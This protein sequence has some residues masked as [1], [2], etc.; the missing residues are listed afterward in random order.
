MCICTI[1]RIFPC[2][3]SCIIL[4]IPKYNSKLSCSYFA[5]YFSSKNKNRNENV[6]KIKGKHDIFDI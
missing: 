2:T 3:Q 4:T 5:D 6:W 1:F